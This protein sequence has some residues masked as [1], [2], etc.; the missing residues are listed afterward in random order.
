MKRALS[1]SFLL[2]TLSQFIFLSKKIGSSG[3]VLGI[4]ASLR[5]IGEREAQHSANGKINTPA[6][7]NVL[8]RGSRVSPAPLPQKIR[9]FKAVYFNAWC[10]TAIDCG[11]TDY[12]LI[13]TQPHR[14]PQVTIFNDFLFVSNHQATI[15]GYT[16]MGKVT[17]FRRIRNRWREVQNLTS[18][19]NIDFQ[20]FG[21]SLDAADGYLVVGAPGRQ[22]GRNNSGAVHLFKLKNNR[23]EFVRIFNDPSRNLSEPAMR[24]YKVAIT[25]RNIV[26][27]L[28]GSV[29]PVTMRSGEVEM[30]RNNGIDWSLENTLS[31]TRG[32]TQ[33]FGYS[34]DASPDMIVI[35]GTRGIV[36][37]LHF[38]PG[39]GW[40]TLGRLT[41]PLSSF[42][43]SF[44][45]E[46]K[47]ER[48]Q[49]LVGDPAVNRYSGAAHLFRYST[50][51]WSHVQTF[52]HPMINE[53]DHFGYKVAL[54]N[55]NIIIASHQDEVD[56]R[57]D[58]GT[59][60]WFQQR[61]INGPYEYKT[62][63]YDQ[64]ADRGY[65]LGSILHLSNKRFITGGRTGSGYSILQGLLQ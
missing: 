11:V 18:P 53:N 7:A 33:D 59:L 24:G 15:N 20:S 44:G 23:W 14:Y 49:I 19:I 48:N 41:N 6:K 61:I 62:L 13:T 31:D 45:F 21:F 16:E 25:K 57:L 46:V 37:V 34:L 40:L 10:P 17:V 1:L 58:M 3:S 54:E 27:S 30:Y 9:D 39:L 55:E 4:H 42:P 50:P 32:D 63:L 5:L 28:F 26:C 29:D 64:S 12:Q 2:L 47:L 60:H 52:R 51:S 8:N 65:Y 22:N 35:G 56:D 38:I 36:H 43:N